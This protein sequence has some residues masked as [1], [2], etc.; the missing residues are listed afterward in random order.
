MTQS[1]LAQRIGAAH[2]VSIAATALAWLR[3]KPTV[4]APIASAS[5]VSQVADLLASASVELTPE[6]IAHLSAVSDAAQG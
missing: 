2:G 6:E 5:R 3:A 1:G 4:V